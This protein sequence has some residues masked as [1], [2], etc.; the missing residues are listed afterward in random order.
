MSSMD[1]GSVCTGNG[2]WGGELDRVDKVVNAVGD[3]ERGAGV[4]QKG[5]C[6]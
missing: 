1:N 5:S 6:S 3:R 4:E 2:D